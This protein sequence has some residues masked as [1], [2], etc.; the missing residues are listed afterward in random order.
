[1]L[2]R[3]AISLPSFLSPLM[4]DVKQRLERPRGIATAGE[5]CRSGAYYAA[6]AS[7]YLAGGKKITMNEHFPIMLEKWAEAPARLC[8]LLLLRASEYRCF[9]SLTA[10]REAVF[11]LRASEMMGFGAATPP[12]H[13]SPLPI[14]ASFSKESIR[15]K[16]RKGNFHFWF[17]PKNQRPRIQERFTE[18][19]VLPDSRGCYGEA[20][21]LRVGG[22]CP[23]TRWLH[24]LS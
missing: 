12:S 13:S 15:G 7:R 18:R 10:G 2:F 6:T 14:L 3:T 16:V 23:S 11:W 17:R 1:M 4:L 22:M 9:V 21:L 20:G 8:L 5:R 19:R 24:I